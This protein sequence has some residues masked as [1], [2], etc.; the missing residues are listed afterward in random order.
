VVQAWS[1]NII[2]A[3]YNPQL[4]SARLRDE[5]AFAA[6]IGKTGV[7]CSANKDIFADLFSLPCFV[8]WQSDLQA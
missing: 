2:D 1:A 8:F 4:T 6:P 7:L 3:I 5:G